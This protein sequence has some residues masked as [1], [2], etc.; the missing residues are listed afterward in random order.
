MITDLNCVDCEI[1]VIKLEVNLTN[2]TGSWGGK[3][4]YS[5]VFSFCVWKNELEYTCASKRITVFS[6]MLRAGG[7]QKIQKGV[8]G[9]HSSSILDT[10]YFSET[11]SS[12]FSAPLNPMTIV[13]LSGK[14]PPTK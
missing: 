2:F 1:H 9:T 13:E 6:G 14:S 5:T 7:N 3:F 8:G 4:Q 10:L 12:I 11:E